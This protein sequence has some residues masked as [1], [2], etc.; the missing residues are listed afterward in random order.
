MCKQTTLIVMVWYQGEECGSEPDF[1]I[2]ASSLHSHVTVGRSLSL[3]VPHFPHLLSGHENR[4][5]F[6]A[7]NELVHTKHLE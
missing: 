3:S 6:T 5:Y 7:L 1:Q 4:T 2:R